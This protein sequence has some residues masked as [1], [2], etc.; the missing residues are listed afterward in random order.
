MLFD[1]ETSE[2]ALAEIRGV[3]QGCAVVEVG[4]VV[5][6]K[7]PV[8]AEIWLLQAMG[9]GDRN[10]RI[11]KDATGLGV[12]GII[13]LSTERTVVDVAG[14]EASK[15]ARWHQIAAE[16]ARQC[17]RPDV[18]ELL[19]P[20]SLQ[21]ASSRWQDA[22][23]V[24]LAPD[25]TAGLPKVLAHWSRALPLLL[26]IGPEGGFTDAELGALA[27][28]GFNGAR[29]GAFVLRMETAAVAA[30]GAVIASLEDAAVSS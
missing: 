21:D 1:P 23:R 2:Q 7:N 19:G 8:A 22:C 11:V 10:D 17:G 13:W 30:L 28:L 14:R 6:V 29:L 5:P 12:R 15:R 16:A 24:V 18:P 4:D 26:A 20:L 25:A 9:K 3:S 27:T